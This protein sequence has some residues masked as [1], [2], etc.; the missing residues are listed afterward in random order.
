MYPPSETM[1]GGRTDRVHRVW[2]HLEDTVED[3]TTADEEAVAPVPA[4]VLDD[5]VG[6]GLDPPVER[7][8]GETRDP[9]CDVD[10]LGGTLRD[11]EER[12]CEHAIRDKVAASDAR[13]S[14]LRRNAVG[15]EDYFRRMIST[16]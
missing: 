4:I 12:K 14:V 11:A 2:S 16:T 3:E 6:L 13:V 10:G 9:S 15:K 1:L 7:D 5:V 8:E